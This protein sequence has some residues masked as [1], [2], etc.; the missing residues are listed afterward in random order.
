MSKNIIIANWKM[1]LDVAES[2][3]QAKLLKK[4]IQN[5]KIKKNIE[6]IVCPDFLSLNEVGK[7]FKDTNIILGAQDGFYVEKGS[8]T[9]E[10][11]M[12][13][14]ADLNCKYVILGHSERRSMGETDEEVNKKVISALSY[15]L[16]P[17]ICVG[18]TFKEHHEGLKDHVVMHQVYQALKETELVLNH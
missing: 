6:I 15:N 16:I 2:V 10:I 12:K 11:S 3:K 18:E 8:Y 4:M 13:E 7:I 9:G 17:I 5:N 14:L 1:Q